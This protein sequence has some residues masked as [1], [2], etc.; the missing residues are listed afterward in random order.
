MPVIL[1][2]PYPLARLLEARA[3]IDA[4]V[5]RD[6]RPLQ[7]LYRSARDALSE[8]DPDEV[9]DFRRDFPRAAT[10][11]AAAA[12]AAV[13][14]ASVW[15]G[16]VS[17]GAG[18][19]DLRRFRGFAWTVAHERYAGGITG[20]PDAALARYASGA[21]LPDISPEDSALF[22]MLPAL[23]GLGPEFPEELSG[24]VPVSGEPVWSLLGLPSD[25]DYAGIDP[26]DGLAV[27]PEVLQAQFAGLP[28][29]WRDLAARCA[30][31]GLLVRS[32]EPLE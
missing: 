23:C 17:V 16:V 26:L 32:A 10:T 5:N 30:D 22:A 20:P 7:A 25:G 4:A 8:L 9:A 1:A 11:D 3:A 19:A 28:P 15:E 14:V 6:L 12:R 18:I 2:R 31:R 27:T 13:A 21:S 29:S 24:P